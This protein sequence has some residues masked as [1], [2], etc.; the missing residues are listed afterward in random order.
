M[1]AAGALAGAVMGAATLMFVDAQA[2]KRH[3]ALRDNMDRYQT[4]VGS[5]QVSQSKQAESVAVR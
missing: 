3:T 2:A 1:V 4:L 5:D